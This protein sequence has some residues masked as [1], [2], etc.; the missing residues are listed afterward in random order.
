MGKY[1]KTKIPTAEIR[2]W[3]LEEFSELYYDNSDLFPALDVMHIH[4]E[5]QRV[6]KKNDELELKELKAILDALCKAP[7]SGI[8]RMKTDQYMMER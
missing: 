8:K 4:S 7:Q 6:H 3:V 2:R 5:F 1:Q